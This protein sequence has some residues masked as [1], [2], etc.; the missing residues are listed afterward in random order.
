MFY[1]DIAQLASGV[2]TSRV[3]RM[4]PLDRRIR[5]I[6]V[7]IHDLFNDMN[8]RTH[9]TGGDL[10][11]TIASRL[12][13][14]YVYMLRNIIL[15]ALREF[16]GNTEK[17]LFKENQSYDETDRSLL[18]AY[19][20]AHF[21]TKNTEN[22]DTSVEISSPLSTMPIVSASPISPDKA[23]TPVTIS[24]IA[25]IETDRVDNNDPRQPVSKTR[26]V[27]PLV[28][29]LSRITRVAFVV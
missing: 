9:Q 14:P 11:A 20:R 24:T 26:L 1:K 21:G 7:T 29:P 5:G 4:F 27:D 8:Y 22:D 2:L 12:E 18:L 6:E 19:I 23:V 15:D 16:A 17:R 3:S 13:N 28:N 10:F 25:S